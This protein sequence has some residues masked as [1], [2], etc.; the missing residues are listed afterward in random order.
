MMK[1]ELTGGGSVVI[2]TFANMYF[3]INGTQKYACY[4]FKEVEV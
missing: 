2:T 1:R 3:T 4:S